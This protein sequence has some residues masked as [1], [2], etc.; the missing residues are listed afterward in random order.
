MLSRA[1]L[2]VLLD[3]HY[4]FSANLSNASTF[5]ILIGAYTMVAASLA[6]HADRLCITY[7]AFLPQL[8]LVSRFSWHMGRPTRLHF[9]LML[10]HAR[11]T[12]HPP[13]LPLV[14]SLFFSAYIA[15]SGNF[16]HFCLL[17]RH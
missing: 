12:K 10:L 17:L 14:I 7:H 8:A 2:A 9:T 3:F 15:H 13:T 16:L 1:I 4:E 5:L 6:I 11:I